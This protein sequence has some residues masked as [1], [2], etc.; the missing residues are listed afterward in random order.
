MENNI[1]AKRVE[2]CENKIDL[3]S[4]EVS[5]NTV[6]M[7]FM[8]DIVNKFEK[9]QDETV[10][11]LIKIQGAMDIFKCELGEIKQKVDKNEE[12]N[13][14]DLRE[15]QKKGAKSTLERIMTILTPLSLIGFLLYL[16]LGQ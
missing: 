2:K 9:T 11:T 10:K 13:T 7:E 5:E 3:L 6:N 15:L 14:I 12:L 1:L 4:R 8:K 16:L